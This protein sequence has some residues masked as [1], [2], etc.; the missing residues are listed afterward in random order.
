[1]DR[2]LESLPKDLDETYARILKSLPSEYAHHT[3]RLLQFLTYSERPLRIEEAVDAITVDEG[4][5][6]RFDP[7]NRMPV[8][9]E[10]VRYCSSLAVR[11][12]RIDKDTRAT[13]V[14]IQLAH[15]SVK[16]Y[17]TSQRPE[18]HIAQ[19]FKETVAHSCIAKVYLIYLCELNQ[20]LSITEIRQSFFL[21]QCAAR[22]WA[23]HAL[24]AERDSQMDME[25]ITEFFSSSEA[26]TICSRLYRPEYPWDKE[27]E[28]VPTR[29]VPP[30]LYYASLVGLSRSV[31]LLLDK[32][33]DINAQGR[34]G[35]ALQRASEGGHEQVVKLLLNKGADINARSIYGTALQ[36]ASEG[37]H[38]Q[39]VKLLLNKGADVNAPGGIYGTVLQVALEGGHKR[40]VKLLQDNNSGYVDEN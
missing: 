26:Y 3:I 25:I 6:P 10:I 34:Y 21:A 39:V 13:V 2:A 33:A 11:V 31:K 20:D 28:D 29:Y 35:T 36:V 40:I 8:P 22:Y 24:V 4:K 17:L 16:D 23:S 38:E 32:G 7:G 5:K 37:G 27:P 19:H 18:E 30:A 12:E 15:F 1:M 9:G 14:E